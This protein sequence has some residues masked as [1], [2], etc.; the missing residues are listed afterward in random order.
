MEFIDPK[1]KRKYYYSSSRKKSAWSLP[2]YDGVGT[3]ATESKL[4]ITDSSLVRSTICYLFLCVC[5]IARSNSVPGRS[6]SADSRSGSNSRANNY[7]NPPSRASSPDLSVSR[8]GS[9]SSV[10]SGGS[11]RGTKSPWVAAT[12]PKSGKTYWYN[13]CECYPTIPQSLLYY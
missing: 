13:R 12:D 7:S 3:S 10:Q 2:G 1:T 11:A 9:N 4:C 8:A 5:Y 6:V